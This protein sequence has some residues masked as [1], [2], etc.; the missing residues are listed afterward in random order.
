MCVEVP[1]A[2]EPVK[3]TNIGIP[4]YGKTQWREAVEFNLSP[5]SGDSYI[6][7]ISVESKYESLF[8]VFFNHFFGGGIIQ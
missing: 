1:L 7:N 3:E 8:W 6:L 4:L 5:Q 2:L